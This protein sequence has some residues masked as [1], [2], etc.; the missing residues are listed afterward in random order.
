MDRGERRRTKRG[1]WRYSFALSGVERF[2]PGFTP[3][4]RQPNKKWPWDFLPEPNTGPIQN[5][6]VNEGGHILRRESAFPPPKECLS[7]FGRLCPSAPNAAAPLA[8]TW[9]A[10]MQLGLH[11]SF[12]IMGRSEEKRRKLKKL[13]RKRSKKKVNP[14]STPHRQ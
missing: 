5:A 10:S 3:S 11:H 14:H 8:A 12:Q 4:L 2:G 13:R 6:Q 9:T 1:Q 7:L